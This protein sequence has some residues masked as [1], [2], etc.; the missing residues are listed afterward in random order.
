M[1][2]GTEGTQGRP[3]RADA[4]RNVEAILV[5]ATDCLQRDAGV[6]MADVARAA[7]VGRVTLYGH[8]GTRAELVAAVFDRTLERAEGTLGG[9]ELD[10]DPTE[11]LVTVL[12]ASWRIVAELRTI[13]L[14]AQRELPPERIRVAHDGVMAR[15]RSLVE[16]GQH[17][18]RFRDDLPADWFVTVI[19]SLVHACADEVEEGRLT[20][21]DAGRYL[22]TTVRGALEP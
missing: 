12:G 22:V 5:A 11:D 6:S 8:F 3:L 10:G 17:A 13:L 19:L 21:D 14:A 9:L 7:G 4:Q 18:G 16:R 15:L 20:A 1:T 2:I